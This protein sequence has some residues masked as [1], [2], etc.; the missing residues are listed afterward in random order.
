MSAL[1]FAQP[2]HFAIDSL[3][4]YFYYPPQTLRTAQSGF[5]PCSE[6]AAK[7]VGMYF[8][9]TGKLQALEGF[10]F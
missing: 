3:L 6:Q 8:A 4:L 7:T 2:S 1:E 10:A 5:P 9:E